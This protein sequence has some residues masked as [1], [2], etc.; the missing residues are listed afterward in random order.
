MLFTTQTVSITTK[1]NKNAPQVETT[2]TLTESEIDDSVVMSALI[3][4]QSPRVRIQNAWREDG[5]PKA[6]TVK[7]ADYITPGKVTRVAV[8][9]TDDEIA[10]GLLSDP[11][12]LKAMLPARGLTTERDESDDE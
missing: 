8:K 12:R 4:G 6:V 11:I 5:I 2:L 7:W 1:V 10:K 9:Q 3:S